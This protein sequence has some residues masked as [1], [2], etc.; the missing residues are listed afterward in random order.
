MTFGQA[1]ARSEV[2]AVTARHTLGRIG[3]VAR[4]G[5]WAG[6]GFREDLVVRDTE[7]RFVDR[8]GIGG[9]AHPHLA[10]SPLPEP[11]VIPD[12]WDMSRL[13]VPQRGTVEK[14]LAQ[15]VRVNGQVMSRREHYANMTSKFAEEMVSAGRGSSGKPRMTYGFRDGSY[16][17]AGFVAVSK[18][19]YLASTLP[20]DGDAA[21]SPLPDAVNLVAQQ[22]VPHARTDPAER[23]STRGVFRGLRQEA[24]GERL[25]QPRLVGG[26]SSLPEGDRL[27]LNHAATVHEPSDAVVNGMV[28][29]NADPV[30]YLELDHTS[31]AAAAFRDAITASKR[32]SGRYGPSVH[33][34]DEAEY[35]QMRLFIDPN[36][37]SGFGIKPDGDIVSAF[38]NPLHPDKP[39]SAAMSI[40]ETA[41][42]NGGTH[43]DGFDPLLPKFYGEHGF[44][45]VS[46]TP[47]DPEYQPEGWSMELMD[48]PDVVFMVADPDRSASYLPGDGEMVDDYDAGVATAAAALHPKPGNTIAQSAVLPGTLGWITE[49]AGRMAVQM[50]GADDEL[51]GP[52]DPPVV[53]PAGISR[54]RRPSR[55]APR[56]KGSPSP[57]RPVRSQRART[58]AGLIPAMDPAFADAPEGGVRWSSR[59]PAAYTSP[60]G[61]EFVLRPRSVPVL[62]PHYG[63]GVEATVRGSNGTAGYLM[64]YPDGEIASVSVLNPH[65]RKGVAT[66]L[67]AYGRTIEPDI[68]HSPVL[69]REGR[70]WSRVAASPL[71]EVPDSLEALTDQELAGMLDTTDMRIE[72]VAGMSPTEADLRERLLVEY[73]RRNP[74]FPSNDVIDRLPPGGVVHLTGDGEDG[75]FDLTGTATVTLRDNGQLWVE[76]ETTDGNGDAGYDYPFEVPLEDVRT[77]VPTGDVVAPPPAP[78]P[79]PEVTAPEVAELLPPPP[80]TPLTPKGG[81]WTGPQLIELS[82]AHPDATFTISDGVN[83]HTG[84]SISGAVSPPGANTGGWAALGAMNGQKL[85]APRGKIWVRKG[86]GEWV[87]AETSLFHTVGVEDPVARSVLTEERPTVNTPDGEWVPLGAMNY[88]LKRKKGTSPDA[89]LPVSLP[90]TING[91]PIYPGA[92]VTMT[93]AA[94]TRLFGDGY[95]QERGVLVVGVGRGTIDVTFVDSPEVGVRTVRGA[96]ILSSTLRHDAT[97]PAGYGWNG[98]RVQPGSLVRA[99]D[100]I[101]GSVGIVLNP[102]PGGGD[103]W[104]VRLPDGRV[105]SKPSAALHVTS[106]KQQFTRTAGD[107]KK[108][109]QL[110]WIDKDG[111]P[112]SSKVIVVDRA[113]DGTM[114]VAVGVDR[115][116]KAILRF[117]EHDPV[118]ATRSDHLPPG[119]LATIVGDASASLGD[120]NL[121][122]KVEQS[123][124]T[125]PELARLARSRDRALREAQEWAAWR[126]GAPGSTLTAAEPPYDRFDTPGGYP[127]PVTN[128]DIADYVTDAERQAARWEKQRAQ[129]RDHLTNTDPGFI[130]RGYRWVP[131]REA[132]G[133]P[134]ET[135]L[136]HLK[137]IR[138]TGANV[139]AAVD[140]R[141]RTMLAER[142][143]DD[144]EVT[145]ARAVIARERMSDTLS[146]EGNVYSDALRRYAAEH[147]G[148]TD[149]WVE[150]EHIDPTEERMRVKQDLFSDE[151]ADSLRK[152]DPQYRALTEE[153]RAH[154]RAAKEL[155]LRLLAERPE[156]AAIRSEAAAQVIKELRPTGGEVTLS[157]PERPAETPDVVE[158]PNLAVGDKVTDGAGGLATITAIERIGTVHNVTVAN[159]T[160]GTVMVA[161]LPKGSALPV[162]RGTVTLT[163]DPDPVALAAF[164]AALDLYPATWVKALAGRGTLHL[165]AEDG[166]GR[167]YYN[168]GA[169]ILSLPHTGEPVLPGMVPRMKVATHEIG[170]SMEASVPGLKALEWA[171]HHERTT[172]RGTK[173]EALR[174]RDGYR[175]RT[176][177]NAMQMVSQ[178]T[179]NPKYADTEQARGDEYPNP[180]T[181]KE[182]G[183]G[184]KAMYELFSMNIESLLA[185]STFDDADSRAWILGLLATL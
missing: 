109:D 131:D 10:H 29:L 169:N 178:I 76:G 115:K 86:D 156:A 112:H 75:P 184:P 7:G 138:D 181:G 172:D 120:P 85:R 63:G 113:I 73:I 23:P 27:Y 161:Q 6:T 48:S 9:I 62:D 58:T 11:P 46:R 87:L 38:A 147:Y 150:V 126:D 70:A 59:A 94:M 91:H 176:G 68:T 158:G 65:Q 24:R 162:Y 88:G 79:A 101:P 49:V 143:L 82:R 64:W 34:Y 121:I 129:Y 171:Y 167:G 3:S 174:D 12:A 37:A 111:Q 123:L 80:S 22:E 16:N 157:H 146:R 179:G 127:Y 67:L 57:G 110:T 137:T 50:F 8:L 144:P 41:V 14:I 61:T 100:T 155:E 185:G 40:I 28:A 168:E 74:Q 32:A 55:Y 25:W 160:T 175:R 2:K 165:A 149:P 47:F 183:G 26:G 83:T 35:Q 77:A 104:E 182:Y 130:L 98:R 17:G 105:I 31:E 122:G 54:I 118:P 128:L 153:R 177:K 107:L 106:V 103:A 117:R 140:D 151:R 132:D 21:Q 133:G 13:T 139:S 84:V 89:A 163:S 124:E 4:G 43:L 102:D 152:T 154:F 52:H 33:V 135:T 148:M 180:Y 114:K 95:P 93:R 1:P 142:S 30:T 159:D 42:D 164:H 39:R 69:S 173:G 20:D 18:L 71:P 15:Q 36:G 53:V 92:T 81:K 60:D 78:D 108:G 119:D 116:D 66:A 56:P 5:W 125:L 96:D 141:Y 44:R 45:A 19:V 170:H 136:A 134:G 99:I 51:K 145:S 166:T 97:P 90:K 72:S